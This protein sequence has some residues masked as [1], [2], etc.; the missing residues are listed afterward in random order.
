M[1]LDVNTSV[2]IDEFRE[3]TDKL[4]NELVK[5]PKILDVLVQGTERLKYENMDNST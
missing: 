4:M 1:C 2:Q 5:N 3:K